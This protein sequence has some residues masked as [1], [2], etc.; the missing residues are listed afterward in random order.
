[1]GKTT[2]IEV[3]TIVGDP[4]EHSHLVMPQIDED[5][6]EVVNVVI[7]G[8]RMTMEEWIR[9][10]ISVA[11]GGQGQKRRVRD[12]HVQEQPKKNRRKSVSEN[13]EM[14][15]GLCQ[16]INN[17]I[18]RLENHV[19]IAKVNQTPKWGFENKDQP[20][21]SRAYVPEEVN[22]YHQHEGSDI[23]EEH[24]QENNDKVPEEMNDDQ[25][26]LRKEGNDFPEEH[27]HDK[28]DKVPEERND[29]QHDLRKEGNDFP[30][31]H[32]HDE[33]DKVNP[34]EVEEQHDLRKDRS[35]F[36]DD[37]STQEAYII[38]SDD[39]EFIHHSDNENVNQ[40]EEAPTQQEASQQEEAS[41]QQEQEEEAFTQQGASQQ[42]EASTQQEKASQQEEP[43]TQQEEASQEQTSL[44]TASTPLSSLSDE[45]IQGIEARVKNWAM[46]GILDM[47][48][49]LHT[50]LWPGAKWKR[51][52]ES[53]L[54]M[55][56]HVKKR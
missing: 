55:E 16:D 13:I 18:T 41:T 28:N 29:D 40:E 2:F 8:Y 12:P 36:P 52:T 32:T 6:N 21:S 43:S 10:S 9:G 53:E 51:V 37:Y 1:M 47:L 48:A 5:F 56:H 20:S 50:M 19:G 22:D 46:K 38:I 34:E 11:K 24:W 17:R 39:E 42:E 30:E 23:P 4:N 33:N 54:K 14:L 35:D 7:K 45:E 3:K 27:T 26:D 15:L 31:E 44:P 49:T 25:P